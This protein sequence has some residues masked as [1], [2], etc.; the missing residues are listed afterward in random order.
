MWVLIPA[1][2]PGGRLPELVKSLREHASILVVDDGSGPEYAEFFD[3]ADR[4]GAVVIAHG[5]NQGKAAAL[6]TGFGWLMAN[7]AGH[8]VVCADS[9]G[10]HLPQDVI[11]VGAEVNRRAA[12][13]A[14]R[15]VVLGV[16]GFSGEVPLR[17]RV[18]NRA[19][20][21]LVTAVTGTRISDTQTGLRGYPASLLEWACG[22]RGE[23]FAYEL[24]LLLEGSR[25]AIPVV[26]V[27]IETVY[28]EHNASSHFRPL[29][30]SVR[31]LSPL[32]LFAASSLVSF[33]LDTGALLI[34]SAVTGSLAVS[35]VGARLLSASVNFALNRRTVFRSHG[36]L[37]PQL[38]RYGAFA[39][40]LLGL[41]YA[42]IAALTSLGV[43][44]V[45]AK[46]TTDAS[47][48]LSS[49]GV[50]RVFV[51]TRESARTGALREANM[52][53]VGGVN[54]R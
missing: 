6:R 13:G 33:G 1:Y 28:L 36:R 10:Q 47:L 7:A 30:D 54:E 34:L 24:W 15:A 23:R 9:D 12:E 29:A 46:I 53:S 37:G 3:A 52:Q 40:V 8:T 2:E 27:P 41:G 17:S 48:W 42:G 45:I 51:F 49:F 4:L 25:Q 21:A 35:V 32:L 22:I 14:P 11:A 5:S 38:L 16:R 20:T 18:G 44:L 31:V 50:Q 26:G 19:M 43:P 39:V